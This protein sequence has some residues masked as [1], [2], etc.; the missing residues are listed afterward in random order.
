MKCKDRCL[1]YE[2]TATYIQRPFHFQQEIYCDGSFTKNVHVTAYRIIKDSH[3]RICSGD[4]SQFLYSSPIIVEIVALLKLVE[5]EKDSGLRTI[6]KLDCL[7][8]I[9]ALTCRMESWPWQCYALIGSDFIICFFVPRSLNTSTNGV[10]K[11]RRIGSL[12]ST[13][14]QNLI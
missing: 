8:I 14:I 13:W 1:L 3:G 7:T 2:N 5:F 4:A 12:L 6:I 9:T 10:A 11:N